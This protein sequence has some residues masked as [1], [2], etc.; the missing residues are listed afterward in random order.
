MNMKVSPTPPEENQPLPSPSPDSKEK[1][2]KNLMISKKARELIGF[3]KESE[4]TKDIR[5]KKDPRTWRVLKKGVRASIWRFIL[6]CAG[7]GDYIKKVRHEAQLLDMR[8]ML[9]FNLIQKKREENLSSAGPDSFVVKDSLTP[10]ASL[11]TTRN[12]VAFDSKISKKTALRL[13]ATSPNFG[14]AATPLTST[15]GKQWSALEIRLDSTDNPQVT[16]ERIVPTTERALKISQDLNNVYVHIS[17]SGHITISCGKI[18]DEAKAKQ[19]MAAV[20]WALKKRKEEEKPEAPLRIGMHQLNGW[21]REGKALGQQHKMAAYINH[22]LAGYLEEKEITV[23]GSPPFLAHIN[24]CMNGFE[25]NPITRGHEQKK[26]RAN[27][28]EGI[29]ANMVWLQEDLA[30]LL[31]KAGIKS[32]TS[33]GQTVETQREELNEKVMIEGLEN[34]GIS[35]EGQKPLITKNPASRVALEQQKLK[36]DLQLLHTKQ[37][38]LAE[39]TSTVHEQH[40]NLKKVQDKINSLNGKLI[41]IEVNEGEEGL[42][43]K[44]LNEKKK[45]VLSELEEAKKEYDKAWKKAA[46]HQDLE[47]KKVLSKEIKEAEKTVGEDLHYLTLEMNALRLTIKEKIDKN[48]GDAE[49]LKAALYPVQLATHILAMQ[50][51]QCKECGLEKLTAAQEVGLHLS[52]DIVLKIISE[53]NCKSGLDRTGFIRALAMALSKSELENPY[54]FLVNFESNV[55]KV[56]AKIRALGDHLSYE[57]FLESLTDE[58]KQVVRFQST[59]HQ[60]LLA[61]AKPITDRSTGKLGVRWNHPSKLGK[62]P[63]PLPYLPAFIKNTDSNEWVPVVGFNK[64]GKRTN[65][66]QDGRTLYQGDSSNRGA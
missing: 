30:P 21:T 60:E 38:A 2:V 10:S 56:D 18:D 5:S 11:K 65:L 37:Q 27:N 54:E 34:V 43:T 6:V 32:T 12:R 29:A 42:T 35:A 28:R 61:V 51:G 14:E 17:D 57:A 46:T 16:E 20:G 63:H 15:D 39:L 36:E 62:N 50:T 55:K 26:D 66:T 19:F 49:A 9:D 33:E 58:Q 44:E 52:L 13:H 31:E 59:M 8:E 7:Y 25:R 41:N 47:S 53:I 22:N 64:S 4:E 45:G 24:R 3:G 1:T 48:D 23:P 40:P